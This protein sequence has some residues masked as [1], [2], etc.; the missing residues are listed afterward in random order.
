MAL[1]A[2][3]ASDTLA[4]ARAIVGEGARFNLDADGVRFER[5]L[6]LAL[7]ALRFLRR[8]QQPRSR[9][10]RGRGETMFGRTVV[11]VDFREQDHPRLIGTP[12]NAAARGRFWIEQGTGR[13]LRSEIHLST[14][15]GGTTVSGVLRVQFAFVP[16]LGLWLPGSMEEEYVVTDLQQR[17]VATV[18]G[19]ASYSSARRFGVNVREAV[20]EP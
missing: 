4:Q 11:V 16:E 3:P 7:A 15:R 9:F 2:D 13:V 12:D 14:R 19:R 5:T 6:N 17:V 8:E 20:A 18:S 10:E 1:F